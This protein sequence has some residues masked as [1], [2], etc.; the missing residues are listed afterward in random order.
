MRPMTLVRR[1]GDRATDASSGAFDETIAPAANPTPLPPTVAPAPAGPAAGVDDTVAPADRAPPAQR[2]AETRPGHAR[3]TAIGSA[4]A[5]DASSAATAAAPPAAGDDDPLPFVDPGL[6]VAEHEVA[7]GGMG[8]IIAAHDRVLGRPVALKELLH[9]DPDHAARFRREALITARLQHPAIVPVYQAGRWPS[10]EPFYAMKLVAGEPLD[11]VIARATT[12][13]ARLALLPTIAAAVDA[14]AFA[15]SRRVVHR[16]LKPA[17][18]LVGD[19]GEIVVI[20]WG[21]AKDLDAPGEDEMAATEPATASVMRRARARRPEPAPAADASA[22]GPGGPGSSDPGRAPSSTLTV[23]GAIMGTPA[24]MPPEQARGDAVDE[25]ADVFSLGAMLY[26]LLAGAPPYAATTATDVIAAAIAGNVVPLARRVADAPA[27]LVAIVTRAMAHDPAARYPTAQALAEELRRFQTGKLVAAHRYTV[28]ERLARFVRRHRAAVAI[29]AFAAVA[30]VVLG[31]LAIRRI[32]A[33]RDRAQAQRVLAERRRAA[34]EGVVDFLMSDMKGRLGAIGRKDLLS[35]MSG[36]VRDYY[37]ALAALPGG[38]TD[39][40]VERLAAALHTL[41]QAERVRGAPDAALAALRDGQA[42]LESIV[43]LAD[44]AARTARLR[45]LAAVELE[46]GRVL[47]DRGD[48]GAEVET[49]RAAL[50]R[51]DEVLA[52]APADRAALLGGAEARDLIADL[53]RN[54]GDLADAGALYA[55]AKAARQQVV[56]ASGGQDTQALASLATSHLKLASTLQARGDSQGALAEYRACEELRAR[57]ADDD[58]EDTDRQ[59]ELVRARIQ[60]ADLERELGRLGPALA[61]YERALAVVDGLLRKDAGNTAWRRDRG[62]ILSNWAYALIDRGDAAGADDK[63]GLALANHAQLLTTDGKNTSWKIDVSRMH[64]RRGDARLWRGAIGEALAEYQ[65]TRALRVELLAKDPRSPLWRRMVA[66]ADSKVA[67]ARW[68]AGDLD[69]ARRSAVAALDVRAELVEASPDQA[70]LRNELALSETIVARVQA[71]LGRRA[72]ALAASDR[73]IAGAG[74]LVAADAANVEWKETLVNALVLR[75]DLRLATGDVRGAR[76]DAERAIAESSL[77][78]AVSPESALWTALA[79]EAR[80][81]HARVLRAAPGS[82]PEEALAAADEQAARTA[83][84]ALAAA[85][86]L[87]ADRA[88]LW[89]RLRGA[90]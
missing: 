54:R 72:D 84:G 65:T 80:W 40:D 2:S 70:G 13:A 88:P 86:R 28:R 38:I 11:K 78:T 45:A 39:G 79:A 69:D 18:V 64:F 61:T 62:I 82:D 51:F 74:A 46:I 89:Q 33:E 23:A 49:Y 87:P 22:S 15:H 5:A 3:A 43:P 44:G 12:L 67:I 66:W 24:Y 10:G 16:D 27:D 34:A 56:D 52:I 48:Y 90:R 75:G 58:P 68:A 41:G 26:H 83:L 76:D 47:H 7:R 20:D 17:N 60:V 14:I 73:A 71:S 59:A 8:R 6:Y 35:G 32:V 4:P 36:A 37:L 31:A 57:L 21:L 85:G 77:A 42:R 63:L 55:A 81:L 50:G 30:F 19:F 29:A 53:A 9:P 25:K 1:P